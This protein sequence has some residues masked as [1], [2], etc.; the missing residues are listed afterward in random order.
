MKKNLFLYLFIMIL[1]A[2]CSSDNDCELTCNGDCLV[3]NEDECEC[4][5]DVDCRCSDGLKNGLEEFTDCG[6]DCPPCAC[7]DDFCSWLSNDSEKSWEM[8]YLTQNP[9]TSDT[10]FREDLNDVQKGVL[11]RFRVDDTFIESNSSSG[12]GPC[13]YNYLLDS[14]GDKLIMKTE[15]QIT[16]NCNAQ[17][18]WDD[19][20]IHHISENLFAFI[21]STSN[22]IS[23]FT[24]N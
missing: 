7:D 21:W 13:T 14:I 23:Y 6:G 16:G 3:L 11:L 4:V 17:D 2:G 19:V 10:L 18:D 12:F 9:P 5:V 15:V 22:F 20:E 24:P 1:F 8:A